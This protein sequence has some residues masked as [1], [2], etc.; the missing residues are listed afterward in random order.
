MNSKFLTPAQKKWSK[1]YKTQLVSVLNADDAL[2]HFFQDYSKRADFN[3]T[4]FFITGDHS[5]PEILLQSKIDRFHVPMMIY[6]PMLKEAKRFQKTI[7]HFDIAPSILAYYRKNYNLKTP[8]TVTWVGKGLASDSEISKSDVPMM[9]SKTLLTDF[10]SEKYYLQD[11]NLFILKNSEEGKLDNPQIYKRISG[12]FN[13]FKKMN[14]K[15]YQSK[16]LMPDSV[17]S[18]FMN[19]AK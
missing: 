8:S 12:R 3:K 13:Q 16:Q 14:S 4:I 11:N 17:Y 19:K 10:V 18:D 15:V 7:S 1:A 2:K 5:M 6:S 9:Q